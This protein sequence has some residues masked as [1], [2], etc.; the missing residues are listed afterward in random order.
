MFGFLFGNSKKSRLR[1]T[2]NRYGKNGTYRV[3]RGVDTT[4]RDS[5]GRFKKK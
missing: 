2:T 3:K 5:L 1:R 4:I